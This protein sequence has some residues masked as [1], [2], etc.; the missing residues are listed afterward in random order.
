MRNIAF[1]REC[2][3]ADQSLKGNGHPWHCHKEFDNMFWL[4]GKV[5]PFRV[6]VH[7]DDDEICT[8]STSSTCEWNAQA[9]G[10]PG[11]TYGFRLAYWQVAC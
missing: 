11:G 2:E 4:L 3:F 5:R 9:S 7:F 1:E 10:T 6:G 8:G